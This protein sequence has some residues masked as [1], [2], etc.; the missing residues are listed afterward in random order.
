MV[1][2]MA[3]LGHWDPLRAV[4]LTTNSQ[5]YPIWT[6]KIDL[7]RDKIIEYKY[8]ILKSSNSKKQGQPGLPG[9]GII[10]WESLPSGVNRLISTHGKKEI[11]IYESL[12]SQE[13]VEEY[14]EA[15]TGGER[16]L[17]M[18]SN[19]LLEQ[20][21][22]KPVRDF[23]DDEEDLNDRKESPKKKHS[24]GHGHHHKEKTEK[25]PGTEIP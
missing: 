19:D 18:S 24:H 11:T 12:N 25:V 3:L 6:I 1:G 5:T 22:A 14:V 10:E 15:A 4:P 16:K 8:L 7:P 2:S 17:F 21:A 23:F 20:A 9:R 13:S